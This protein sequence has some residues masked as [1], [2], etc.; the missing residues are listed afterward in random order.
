MPANFPTIEKVKRILLE[1][2]DE[3]RAVFLIQRLIRETVP[4][5]NAS[6]DETIRRMAKAFKVKK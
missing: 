4:S 5:G 6:Y 2:L 3:T 1:E